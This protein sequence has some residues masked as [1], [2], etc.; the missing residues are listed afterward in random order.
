MKE[1]W[2]CF[3]PLFVAVDAI[4]VLPIFINLCEGVPHNRR[5]VILT[6]SVFTA[7]L[8]AAAFLLVG[9][10][11]L[12]LLGITVADFMVAGGLLLFV[13]SL[14]DLLSPEKTRKK[15]DADG[16]GA[17]PIGVPL[18]TGPAVLTTCML[19]VNQHGVEVTMAAVVVNVLLAGLIFWFAAPITRFLGHAGTR[20]LSKIASLL[21]ASI[22]VMM[23]RK[24]VA[25]IILNS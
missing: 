20:T 18:I 5:N 14:S 10:P 25:L 24:G 19:L 2:I 11:L 12:A 15:V 22:A 17:V 3:V 1:F 8:V 13:L 9:R 21:L 16:I 4:G 23:V 7:M 6:Q